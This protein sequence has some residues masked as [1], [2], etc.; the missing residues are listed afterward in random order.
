[1]NRTNPTP[2]DQVGDYKVISQI[3]QQGEATIG[4]IIAQL[5]AYRTD[6]GVVVQ[7]ARDDRQVGLFILMLSDAARQVLG[8]IITEAG[9]REELGNDG[10]QPVYF[11]KEPTI[12]ELFDFMEENKRQ[13]FWAP[14]PEGLAV[15]VLGD[16]ICQ[17]LAPR[18]TAA[19]CPCSLEG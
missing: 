6:R 7:T 5:K 16:E 1:M 2:P 18:L 17:W 4:G 12:P 10:K 3:H 19:G 11:E 9:L 8:P 14:G 15:A 13:F